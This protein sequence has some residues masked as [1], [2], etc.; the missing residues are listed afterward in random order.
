[1][2]TTLRSLLL[3]VAIVC[4]G[5]NTFAEQP[6]ST[7]EIAIYDAGETLIDWENPVERLPYAMMSYFAE[8]PKIKN[9]SEKKQEALDQRLA[10]LAGNGY[11]LADASAFPERWQKHFVAKEF[12]W[13]NIQETGF[14]ARLFINKVKKTVVLTIAGTDFSDWDSISSALYI[15]YGYSS[16][17]MVNGIDLAQDLKQM[18]YSKGYQIEVTGASQGGAIAQMAA[19][20]TNAAAYVFNSQMPH[21]SV[22]DAISDDDKTLIKHAYIEGDM[23]NDSFLHPAGWIIQNS[24][25]VET[26]E[27]P[28]D[29]DLEEEIN[30]EYYKKFGSG[31]YFTS[32]A[33]KRHWTGTVL[34]L[35]EKLAGKEFLDLYPKESRK[36][37]ESAE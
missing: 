1:M 6:G 33:W 28:V 11:T 36:K 8:V 34:F 4:F 16:E 35:S 2:K 14:R 9:R 21:S 12:D 3:L 10:Y 13:I 37:T 31:Y 22:I 20:S 26:I 30:N 15:A 25:T 24:L 17:A 23:L 7:T 19:Y 29:E 32:T 5:V 18:Y 27:L